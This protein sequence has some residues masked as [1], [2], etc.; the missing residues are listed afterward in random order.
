MKR[1]V[2]LRHLSL[3]ALLSLVIYSCSKELTPIG[4]GLV[5]DVDL[6]NMGYTDT[7]KLV[8]YSIPD[9]SIYTRNLNINNAHYIQVG[10]MYDPVFG[11]TT[12]NLYTQLFL[13]AARTRF[14]TSPVFDSAFLYLNYKGSYGDTLSNMTFSVY[15]LTGDIV[16]SL[17]SYSYSTV[18][19]DPVPI[20]EITFQPRPHDSAYFGGA[21]HSPILRI[22]INRKFGNSVL[23]ITDT[24]A[25]NTNAAFIKKF[26]GIYIA[27][28]PQK[29]PGKGSIITFQIPSDYLLLRMYY[30]NSPDTAKTY[31]F[32]ISTGC[33]R[34]QNY[35]HNGHAE[36]IPA[37][38]QQLNGNTSLGEQFLF[39]QGLGGTKIK[40]RFPYLDKWINNDKI[41]INDAQ[42]VIGNSSVSPVFP[43]P[44][45]LSL[46]GVG[47]NGTTSPF[48]IVDESDASGY[49]DGTYNSSSN[50]YRFRITRYVQ[51]VILG[52]ER[53]NGMHLIIPSSAVNPSRLILNGT[54]STQSD[55]K[56][57]LRYTILQ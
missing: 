17:S 15:N 29:T 50:S 42:L 2:F 12:S 24:N 27:A 47:E 19:Y 56:L 38:K 31:D 7:V 57:Y 8:A 39:A 30:H 45:Y 16:D 5:T 40:I 46:H 51:Q 20:G 21:K 23:G 54:S 43:N 49:F 25:L 22:P 48:S 3:V 53:N 35:T 18:S 14:G 10:S 44:G 55:M 52:K 41:V 34:F 4:L 9:D 11:I 33:S 6:L 37:L 13:T 26:K 32:A 1:L 28:E 36:A